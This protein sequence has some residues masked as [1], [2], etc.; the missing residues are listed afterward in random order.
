MKLKK[1]IIFIISIFLLFSFSCEY[2]NENSQQKSQ[3]K[4]KKERQEE[5]DFFKKTPPLPSK[6]PKNIEEKLRDLFTPDE[7]SPIRGF[8]RKVTELFKE[9]SQGNFDIESLRKEIEKNKRKEKKE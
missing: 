6:K 2:T 4:I 1:L 5:R 8:E 3:E 9:F 7:V